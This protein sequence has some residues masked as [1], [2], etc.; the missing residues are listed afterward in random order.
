MTVK[1]KYTFENC[2]TMYKVVC[3]L[4]PEW[5][6]KF[7]TDRE[8]TSGTTRQLNDLYVPEARTDSGGRATTVSGPKLCNNLPDFYQEFGKPTNF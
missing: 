3:G 8:K 1:D 2:I 4:Y 6:M 5:Y 7:S